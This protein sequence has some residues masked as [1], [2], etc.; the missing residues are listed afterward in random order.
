MADSVSLQD[1][2]Y[3]VPQDRFQQNFPQYA[4]IQPSHAPQ[5][6][7]QPL[8]NNAPMYN[9]MHGVPTMSHNI[10][11]Q[12]MPHQH[13]HHQNHSLHS[14]VSMNDQMNSSYVTYDNSF[15]HPAKEPE[16]RPK[17]F[18]CMFGCERSFAARWELVRHIRIH[19]G[20]KPYH[21]D[22]DG[23]GKS[24]ANK[25]ALVTHIRV[26]TEEKPF[27]CTFNDCGRSFRTNH[28]RLYHHRT[29]T[30]EKPYMCDYPGCY[31]R[32]VTGSQ[33]SAH[34]K[35][36]VVHQVPDPNKQDRM[37]KLEEGKA[38]LLEKMKTLRR[39][40][41]QLKKTAKRVEKLEQERDMYK[42]QVIE[43]LRA[44]SRPT[45][46]ATAVS[47]SSSF[48]SSSSS[49]AAAGGGG[50]MSGV[51]GD[52]GA[53]D[54]ALIYPPIP[55]PRPPVSANTAP[56]ARWSEEENR[57]FL[58]GS[59]LFQ[60]DWKKIAEYL[61]HT[62]TVAQVRAHMKV[63]RR[64]RNKAAMANKV[65][66]EVDRAMAEISNTASSSSSSGDVFH[67]NSSSNNNNTLSSSTNRSLGG[68]TMRVSGAVVQTDTDTDMGTDGPR[69][70]HHRGEEE[71]EGEDDDSSTGCDVG[72]ED[73]LPAEGGVP[74]D[75][76]GVS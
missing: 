58:E 19:T 43:L 73:G 69:D 59:Q 52:S 29:H 62:K 44:T 50:V 24:F 63:V 32:F 61:G 40:N 4:Q 66:A 76:G 64:Q 56:F 74:E 21:C 47:S 36:P 7:M 57:K 72:G 53:V 48:S 67:T 8:Y 27:I 12:M 11:A 33:L 30:G 54:M 15:L 34:K 71:E 2:S 39:E 49:G 51:S 1:L 18:V 42:A 20:E 23:C 28:A 31:K 10:Q 75:F 35:S 9:Q 25:E 37:H 41:A 17:P 14:Q 5:L 13:M 26:H 6:S 16:V 55:M 60:N 38:Q 65:A 45:N 68:P 70:I 22:A 3:N 46:P